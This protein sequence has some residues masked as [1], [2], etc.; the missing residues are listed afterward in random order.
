[1][2]I[3]GLAIIVVLIMLGVLFAI[4]F[5]LRAPSTTT[6]QRYK[7]SQLSAGLVTSML[8]TTTSCRDATVTELLQDCAIFSR[9]DCNGQT[10]CAV[11][12]DAFKQ[13]LGGTLRAWNRNYRFTITGAPNVEVIHDESGDCSGEVEAS[14]N[15]VPTAGA[16]LQVTL[17][18]C[19]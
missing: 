3:L 5:V 7:E 4:M 6:E 16:P 12:D 13:M 19:S 2:E 1:M 9:L 15:P 10:S 14:T 17:Q 8:G 11:A 18:L